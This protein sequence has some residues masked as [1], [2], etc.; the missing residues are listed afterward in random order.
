[1]RKVAALTGSRIVALGEVEKIAVSSLVRQR[2]ELDR[3]LQVVA[4]EALTRLGLD[5]KTKINLN[6]EQMRWEISGAEEKK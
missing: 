6:L 3:Q 2:L 5:P 1:M 4:G